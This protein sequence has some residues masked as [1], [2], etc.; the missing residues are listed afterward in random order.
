MENFV[1]IHEYMKCQKQEKYQTARVIG[2]LNQLLKDQNVLLMGPGRW[3]TTT[4][5]LGVPVHFTEI[6]N[7]AAMCEISYQNEGM[8]PEISYG[9]HFFQDLVESGL[10]P[11]CPYNLCDRWKRTGIIFGYHQAESI[12]WTGDLRIAKCKLLH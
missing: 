4:P 6:S 3:G 7:M 11:V 8:M 10:Q 9:S 5:S 12:L 2:R 1:D